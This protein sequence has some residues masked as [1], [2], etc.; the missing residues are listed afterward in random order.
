MWILF[1]V[2]IV[3]ALLGGVFRYWAKDAKFGW[4]VGVVPIL[5]G[6]AIWEKAKIFGSGGSEGPFFLAVF[7]FSIGIGGIV[8]GIVQKIK[9]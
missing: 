2:L 5:S 8:Y 7:L 9:G 1:P 6:V 4:L 3:F